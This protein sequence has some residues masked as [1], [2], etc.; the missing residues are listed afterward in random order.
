[1][2]RYRERGPAMKPVAVT[3]AW[4]KRAT[5]SQIRPDQSGRE[6]MKDRANRAGRLQ[7]HVT[8]YQ[9]VRFFRSGS[10]PLISTKRGCFGS[11][12]FVSACTSTPSGS[13]G[14][15]VEGRQDLWR[16]PHLVALH[17]ERLFQDLRVE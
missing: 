6:R 5:P 12:F 2:A 1:M 14:E 15:C 13:R 16:A 11:L 17:V 10:I 4:H 7:G 9:S 3:N 8:L